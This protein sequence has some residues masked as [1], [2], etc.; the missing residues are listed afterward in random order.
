ME[1]SIISQQRAE[2]PNGANK[3]L[4]RRTLENDFANLVPLIKKGMHVL[5]VGC[6][7][8][9]ITKGIAERVGET[10]KVIGLD[11]N[12]ELIAI[13]KQKFEA[14][15]NLSFVNQ[16][17]FEFNPEQKFDLIVSARTLQWLSNP[18]DA[19]VTM[20]AMLKPGGILSILDY[21]HEKIQWQPAP[22]ESMQF[23]YSRFLSWRSDA[24]MHNQIA[25]ELEAMYAAIGLKNISVD[26]ANE[27]S[28]IE[29]VEFLETAGIWNKVVE[30]R[31]HQ[32]IRDGYLTEE[33]RVNA[34]N[35]YSRWLEEEGYSMD[36]Y[37]KAVTGYN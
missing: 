15:T 31:G 14:I 28:S 36:L 18:M 20:K 19:L 23:F 34:W 12:A 1:V 35:S 5:D 24:G 3:V 6:G 32:M 26:D 29:D 8:G 2:M 25:D 7:S 21:N 16:S 9:A 30:T 27:L 17:L 22:Q 11:I 4:D 37:L 33:Q 13:G 10:G